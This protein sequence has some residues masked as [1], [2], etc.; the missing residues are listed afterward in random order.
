MTERGVNI[1]VGVKAELPAD[2]VRQQS[3]ALN[4]ALSPFVQRLGYMGDKVTFYRFQSALKTLSRAKEVA[5][6]LGLKLKAPPLKF[7]IPLVED[8][9]LEEPES[10]LNELLARLLARAATADKFDPKFQLYRNI[11]KQIGHEESVFL[12]EC[13]QFLATLER[14]WI[15][16]P[17]QSRIEIRT[18]DDFVDALEGRARNEIDES[19]VGSAFTIMFRTFENNLPVLIS[20]FMGLIEVSG[21]VQPDFESVGKLSEKIRQIGLSVTSDA[22]SVNG[23]EFMRSFSPESSAYPGGWS[24]KA[25]LLHLGLLSERTIVATGYD[26]SGA[27]LKV[28]LSCLVRS[29]LGIDFVSVCRAPAKI[30]A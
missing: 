4:D 5:D 22:Y 3:D 18:I 23:R 24:S 1:D 13:W 17:G 28:D 14:I 21:S 20:R 6:E 10:P 27:L 26:K 7:L 11:L 12:E 19:N 9:S 29:S 30:G 8:A 2:V 15:N 25:L 16:R